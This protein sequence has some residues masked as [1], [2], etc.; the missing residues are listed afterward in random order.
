M[1]TEVTEKNNNTKKLKIAIIILTIIILCLSGYIY[2]D[3]VLKINNNIGE[4]SQNKNDNNDEN[5]QEENKNNKEKTIYIVKDETTKEKK[6]LT[7]DYDMIKNKDDIL[8]EYKC[9]NCYANYPYIP[10]PEYQFIGESSVLIYN[11]NKIIKYNYV[12]KKTED[13]YD[14]ALASY[15]LPNDNYVIAVQKDNKYG[16]LGKNG[17]L[18]TN[19]EY[20]EIPTS[21]VSTYTTDG[22]FSSWYGESSLLRAK[23]DNK[24]GIIDV[25]NGKTII[26]FKYEDI[27]I[28]PNGYYSIKEN[29]KWYLINHE[30][31]KLLN[32]GYD[33]VFACDF[34]ILVL[35]NPEGIKLN[36]KI[37]DY[38]GNDIS[39]IVELKYITLFAAHNAANS[40]NLSYHNLL[41]NEG[42]S[43]IRI[44]LGMAEQTFEYNQDKKILNVIEP[45]Y[46]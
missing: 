25:S 16:F 9:N 24:Y 21:K 19:Y 27:I 28:S 37:I 30:L 10:S 31:K 20:D 13:T 23:K 11:N 26:D 46:N 18:I 33:G 42:K 38:D 40:L 35:E 7:E 14:M 15:D 32:T 5:I 17:N 4:N 8:G 41:Y 1:S 29:D 45:D 6:Y 3:K 39:N 2:Y 12:T 36:A 22:K 34:G 43:K 44:S